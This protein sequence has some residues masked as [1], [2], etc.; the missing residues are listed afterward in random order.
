[1]NFELPIPPELVEAI[2]QRAALLM[3]QL[4]LEENPPSPYM[5]VDEA[6]E[7]L[8]CR[9]K[10]IYDLRTSGRLARYSEGGRALVLR[11][12]VERLVV[13]EDV[14]SPVRAA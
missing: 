1:V 2:A 14:A 12:E 7:F 8:R 3:R 9:P 4:E 5:T 13:D 11:A 10:R 6:A